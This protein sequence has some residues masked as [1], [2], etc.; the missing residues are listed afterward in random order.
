MIRIAKSRTL[1]FLIASDTKPQEREAFVIHTAVVEEHSALLAMLMNEAI[2]DGKSG[3]H[4]EYVD[5]DTFLIFCEYAYTGDYTLE[6]E[7]PALGAPQAGRAESR[8]PTFVEISDD[9]TKP[10]MKK[11][12]KLASVPTTSNNIGSSGRHGRESVEE[13]WDISVSREPRM[14]SP[15]GKRRK[16][17]ERSQDTFDFFLNHAR[18]YVFAHLY[19]IAGLRD[20]AVRKLRR[21]LQFYDESRLGE[22]IDAIR[23]IYSNGN[24]RD[25]KPEEDMDAL[26]DTILYFLLTRF[27]TVSRDE[28]VLRLM[29]KGGQFVRDFTYILGGHVKTNTS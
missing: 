28:R 6:K 12:R 9:D 10:A 16:D 5:R 1:E 19:D 13:P 29:E 2:R 8:H 23:F 18:V 15:T 22:V 4:V 25:S 20:L 26:R 11:K 21:S 3:V 27:E 7:Q 17:L 24:T 14:L